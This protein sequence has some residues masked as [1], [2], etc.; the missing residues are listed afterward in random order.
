MVLRM[1][2]HTGQRPRFNP[3]DTQEFPLKPEPMV[4]RSIREGMRIMAKP[5]P[6]RE[7]VPDFDEEPADTREVLLLGRAPGRRLLSDKEQLAEM[8]RVRLV[9]DAM[10]GRIQDFLPPCNAGASGR[11]E[12]ALADAASRAFLV[13]KG[14]SPKQEFFSHIPSP[15]MAPAI[16]MYGRQSEENG[17][18]QS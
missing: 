6:P 10:K 12:G 13:A 17:T 18:G 15:L 16:G 2:R 5:A 9:L 11:L 14:R 3:D 7:S 8:C 4:S 1:I